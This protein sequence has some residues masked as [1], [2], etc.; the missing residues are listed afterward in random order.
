MLLGDGKVREPGDGADLRGPPAAAHGI[1]QER[2]DGIERAARP[3]TGEEQIRTRRFDDD[4]V[5]LQTFQAQVR[6]DFARHPSRSDQQQRSRVRLV[7]GLDREVRTGHLLEKDRKLLGG[8]FLRRRGFRIHDDRIAGLPTGREPQ[9]RRK[10]H[11]SQRDREQEDKAD[12]GVTKHRCVNL[13]YGWKG[14]RQCDCQEKAGR[15]AAGGWMFQ[16]NSRP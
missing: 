10:G 6:S 8:V 15:A 14:K 2:I 1:F 11:R 16:S 3:I 7:G 4:A 13:H 12:S 9:R 5:G